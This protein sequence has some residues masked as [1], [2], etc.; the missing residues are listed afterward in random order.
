MSMF[1]TIVTCPEELHRRL[2][3]LFMI[4]TFDTDIVKKCLNTIS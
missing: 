1:L 3:S 4:S 2:M